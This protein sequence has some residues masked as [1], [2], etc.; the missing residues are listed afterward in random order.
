VARKYKPR[1]GLQPGTTIIDGD[2]SYTERHRVLRRIR[3]K[4][5]DHKCADCGLGA[6]D[7]AQVHETNGT[8][9]LRHYIP[10]CRHCHMMYD[11]HHRGILHTE[12]TKEKLRGHRPQYSG[13]RVYNSRFSIEII[14]WLRA[15]YFWE[16]TSYDDLS[17]MTGIDKS[18]IAQ[19]IRGEIWRDE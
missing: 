16:G 15:M 9:I 11:G 4:A 17:L 3:G 2:A 5:R 19:I 14:R 8:D 7:W 18:S 13:E 6:L 1:L 12:E 10:L